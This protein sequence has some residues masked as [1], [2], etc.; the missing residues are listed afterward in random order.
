MNK[1]NSSF[2]SWFTVSSD[3]LTYIIL[4][5]VAMSDASAQYMVRS[6]VSDVS[7]AFPELPLNPSSPVNRNEMEK[8]VK[9]LCASFGK[10]DDKIYQ[11][12]RTVDT[13][14][15]VMKG[16]IGSLLQNHNHLHDIENASS[17]MRSAAQMFSD[18]G[19]LLEQKLKRRNR[20]MMLAAGGITLF[21]V[22]VLF[23]YFM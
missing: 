9:S 10:T 14:K 5:D 13:T 6:L 22:V 20:M 18:K 12:K 4:A 21:F 19:R 17:S 11:A 15:N 7:N 2:G 3:R 1:Q 8:I 23:M 16:N